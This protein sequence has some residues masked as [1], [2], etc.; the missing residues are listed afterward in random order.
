[1]HP[2]LIDGHWRPADATGSFTATNPA[3]GESLAD[4]YPV[5]SANDVEEALAAAARAFCEWEKLPRS[6]LADFLRKYADLVDQRAETIARAAHDETGLPYEPRLKGVELP[7]T[8]GQL[9]QAADACLDPAWRLPVIDEAA[10]LRSVLQPIGPVLVLGPNNFPLAFNGIS[11]GDFAAAVAAGCPVIAKAHRSHPT[12]SRLLA[13][14]AHEAAADL[15]PGSVQMIFAV[16]HADGLA[17]VADPRLGAAA[18][19]GSRSG[20]LR[21]K[22]AADEVGKP[23]F[24]ELS[25]INPVIV[26]PGTLVE[27][28]DAM[29]DETATSGLMGAGQFCTN[30]GLI[31]TLAGD[32]TERFVA[33][34]AERYAAAA[35]QPLLGPGVLKCLAESVST[36]QAAGAKLIQ[37][38]EAA[39]GAAIAHQNTL[40]RIDGAAFLAQPDALQTEAFGPCTLVA[41][42]DDIEQVRQVLSTL[43]G[44]L[45]GCIYSATDGS[46]DAAYDELAPVLAAR[47]GR[48]LNDKMPTG[49]AV[50]PAM[51]HGGPFPATGHPHFTAVGLPAACRRFTRLACFDNVRPHRLPAILR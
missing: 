51:N 48:L 22:R 40:L 12:T 50:S 10:N 4:A 3:T 6:A 18:F 11:G 7:R 15:P 9:R 21:L 33:A 47:V 43:E 20:G 35:P 2:V 17:M 26:L 45:T 37:G 44:S 34:V 46:D 27:R 32:D 5:S 31:I 49:V 25:A 41:V 23:F 29:V 24:A 42:C 39:E 30:P 8:T 16:D 1:M 13:E 14:A 28:F 19:T 36:L 38:G